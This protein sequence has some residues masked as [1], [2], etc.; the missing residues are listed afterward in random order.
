[1]R[2]AERTREMA[3]GRELGIR[4][5]LVRDETFAQ[6]FLRIIATQGAIR[7][8]AGL[9]RNKVKLNR[10]SAGSKSNETG[11]FLLFAPREH[12]SIASNLN[13]TST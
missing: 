13:K 9:G 2:A 8:R 3:R 1:M 4:R 11:N 6:N 12:L 7:T 5:F 10:R